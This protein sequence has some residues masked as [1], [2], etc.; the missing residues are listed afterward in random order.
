MTSPAASLLTY[1]ALL[2][3]VLL[4]R[5]VWRRYQR[6]KLN[7]LLTARHGDFDTLLSGHN[8]YYNSLSAADRDRFLQRVLQFID[9]KEFVYVDLEREESMPLLISAAAIQLTFGL[10]SFRL[11]YFRTIYIVRDRYTF[12][13]YET[14]FEGHV[15]GDGIYLSWT[16]FVR[17]FADY[18]DGQNVG[19]HEMAH[20]LTYVNF[21]VDEGRDDNFYKLFVTFSAVARPIYDGMKTGATTLLGPY[22]ATNYQ[23]FWAV[24]VENFFER[25]ESFKAELP[26]LYAALC[27]LLNQDPLTAAKR[28]RA[29]VA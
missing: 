22:A 26:E 29:P 14:P 24:C 20:A 5:A 16:H 11:D 3:G 28:L 6:K 1:A 23:E 8:P 27:R 13:A 21:T 9:S 10:D 19:L 17:E 12:G 15:A 25:S 7:E 4:L 18:T 2:A